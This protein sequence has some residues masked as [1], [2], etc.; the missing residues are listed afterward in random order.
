MRLNLWLNLHLRLF[1]AIFAA[2]VKINSL[3]ITPEILRLISELDVFKGAWLALGNLSP[4][5]LLQ[6]RKV[7]TL[8]SIGSQV[9][10]RVE[11]R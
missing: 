5:T 6:L 11:N 7:A 4:D 1:V 9:V 8:E 3:K 2:M 10:Q